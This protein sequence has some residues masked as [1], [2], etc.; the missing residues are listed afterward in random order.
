MLL[1]PVIALVLAACAVWGATLTGRVV[2]DHTG[3]P[4]ASATVRVS[5]P[6]QSF[7]AAELETDREGRFE[8]ADLP[9][10]EY[11]LE[12]AKPNFAKSLLPITLGAAGASTTARLIRLGVITGRVHDLQNQ[13]VA[14]AIVMAIPKPPGDAPLR[15]PGRTAYLATAD[16]TGEYRIRGLPPGE[17]VVVSTYGAS[18]RHMG[19]MGRATTPENLGSGF[20]FYPTNTRPEILP[21][22]G[23]EEHRNID[24][25][26]QG[27]TLHSV[28]GKVET[29]KP[30][31]WFW[32][33]LVDPR[34]PAVSV[35]VA[36]TDKDGAFR[37]HGVPDGSYRLMAVENSRARTF[38]GGI[39]TPSPV[40]GQTR[41]NVGGQNVEGV[42]VRP[43]LARSV[44]FALAAAQGCQTTTQLQLT[45]LE[46]WGSV[47]E[48]SIQ[49]T[50]GQQV[51]VTGLA[52]MRYQISSNPANAP[53]Y[54]ESDAILDL[55]EAAPSAPVELR[56]APAAA[57]NGRLDAAGRPPAE[58]AIVLAPA[59]DPAAVQMTPVDAQGRFSFTGLR[60]GRYRIAAYPAGGK[61]PNITR[62]FEFELRGG[63]NAGIDL[64]APQEGQ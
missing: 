51:S 63:A 36:D 14:G 41:V 61:L 32:L 35:A 52:P 11:R 24:F 17:Y 13:P 12:I 43:E 48:R 59:A 9:E 2:E 18:T 38:A 28:A 47:L 53:C 7:L 40:F 30:E 33:A 57:V 45:P 10:G 3:L 62:M 19:S 25:T 20:L 31:S 6:G 42:T 16:A 34:Q 56:L 50:A 5:Q 46:D 8:A 37:F 44:E 58:F 49:I 23:G 15:P 1:R 4:L 22:T 64:A 55:G 60:P 27:G 26:L 39:P 29:G 54:L 21:I